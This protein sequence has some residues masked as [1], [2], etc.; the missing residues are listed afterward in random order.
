MFIF[1]ERLDSSERT[2]VVE[3]NKRRVLALGAADGSQPRAHPCEKFEISCAA[4][5][6][7]IILSTSNF[8]PVDPASVL[9]LDNLV[10][11]ASLS[12]QS[13]LLRPHSTA[14]L[15]IFF[16]SPSSLPL[17]TIAHAQIFDS[18][19]LLPHSLITPGDRV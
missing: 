11:P 5:P 9:L 18:V 17:L 6:L 3:I 19:R 12:L 8:Y 10:S 13:S 1:E 2:K 4:L 16:S 15:D 7:F 14:R